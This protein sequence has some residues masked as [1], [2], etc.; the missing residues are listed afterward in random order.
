MKIAVVDCKGP[1]TVDSVLELLRTEVCINPVLDYEKPDFV[2]YS[3]NGVKHLQYPQSVK[4]QINVESYIP[5]FN[6]C[7]YAISTVMLNMPERCLWVPAFY[8]FSY[9]AM[10]VLPPTPRECA[11]NRKF[12]VFMYSQEVYG[13]GAMLRKSLC[14]K[15]HNEYKYV[16]CPG[17][18]LHNYDAEELLPRNNP[19][20]IKSKREYLNKFKFC[21]AYENMDLPGYITEKLMDCYLSNTVPIYWGSSKWSSLFPANSMICAQNFESIDALIEY[22]KRVDQDDDLYMSI[23][24]NNPLR[25]KNPLEPYRLQ[26]RAFVADIIKRGTP[27][28]EDVSPFSIARHYQNVKYDLPPFFYEIGS[29]IKKL[30]NKKYR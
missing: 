9:K 28:F 11:I 3:N 22:I 29:F 21:I 8:W 20:W 26:I 23:L 27:L 14:Q 16:E 7:D 17:K 2:F 13:T 1:I 4:I 6:D 12:C 24:N 25:D 30:Y 18:V 10:R 15:L 19:N 5:D